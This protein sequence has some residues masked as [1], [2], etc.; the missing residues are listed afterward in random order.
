MDRMLGLL[1]CGSEL[2]NYGHVLMATVQLLRSALDI[3]QPVFSENHIRRDDDAI[4]T[5]LGRQQWRQIAERAAPA[6]HLSSRPCECALHY[7]T[8]H[9]MTEAAVGALRQR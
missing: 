6:A 8:P 5:T 9:K 7:C 1:R 3:H 2:N 4:L